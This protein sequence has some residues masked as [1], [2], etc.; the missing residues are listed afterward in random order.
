MAREKARRDRLGS[1]RAKRS[2]DRTPEPFGPIPGAPAAEVGR[3]RLFVVQKHDARRLHYDFRLELGGVLLSW[4]V[5]K[6][7]STDPAEK[8]FAA[9]VE[10]HPVEYADFEGIIPEGNYGAGP[11]IVWD[12]GV[13]IPLEDPQEGLEKGKLL[14]EL[15]GYKMRGVWTLVR[16]KGKGKERSKDWLLIKHAG[17]AWAGPEGMRAL[18]AESIYSGLTLEEMRDGSERA[19]EIRRELVRLG[20]PRHRVDAPKV[21]LMLAET[22]ERPFDRP[23]WIFELKYDGFRVL[24]AREDGEARLLYRRG[25]DS[26]SVFP[27]VAR[28]LR[29]LP[30][31]GI[32]LDGEVVVLDEGARPSF[33][34]LQKRALLQRGSDIARAAVE[35]PATL[36]VF[37]L[38]AFEDFDLRPLPLVGRKEVLRRILPRAGPLRFADHVEEGGEALYAQVERLRLEGIMAK[39]ADAPYRAGRSP[40]WLKL[41]V[42]RTGDF[43]VVGTSPAQGTRTAFGAL[44]VGA[45]EG[46]R[47]VYAGKVGSGF[48]EEDLVRIEALLAS[49]RRKAP[50]C[51][52]P[53]PAGRG[54]VWVEPRHVCEVRYKEWTREGLL[55]QPVFLRLRDD[56]PPEECVREAARPHVAPKALAAPEPDA[57]AERKV[58]FTNLDKVFWPDEGYTKGDLIA[59]YRAIAPWLL[60]YL[61]D[62]PVVLTRYPDGIAGK[63]FFQKDAPGFV[64]GWV[65]TE[66][67]WSEHAQREIDYFVCDDV[68]T[69][70]YL[71]NLGTIPL[72][73]WSSRVQTLGSPD[74]CILDL[75]PKGAPFAHVVELAR[76]VHD[77]CEEMGLPSFPKTSGSTGLHVLVPLG[78]QC[79]YEQSR[80]LGEVMAR[81]LAQRLPEIATTTRAV[82]ARGGRVYV[83]YLQNGHGRLLA[84]P[85]SARPRPGAT[86]STPLTWKEVNGRLDPERFTMKT[87]PA[88]FER[89]KTDP[90]RPVLELKPDLPRALARLAEGLED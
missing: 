46:G 65:R 43:V 85:F 6:G 10:D 15:R 63:N 13:W 68:E 21:G 64:P 4:A 61:E 69:L 49:D 26:T 70:L 17:D 28:A 71:A 1:Y 66:R 72:H 88:R 35:L 9:E 2:A 24:A 22:A 12:R 53:V 34:R 37:D 62:R 3:P 48:G 51:A 7:P 40:H 67:M 18:A 86:V 81:T 55:R 5:P 38:L 80:S 57:A 84:S 30:F 33:E 27:E 54:H 79:T 42:D 25:S 23:G 56:K 60:P 87:V 78:R 16:I 83:D 8:R 52:G 11:V 89:L 39:K 76:A 75:D 47:L 36:Y 74:W 73:I 31:E 14:F 41:R 58:P 50:P 20:A 32:V 19:D 44:H 59:F 29:G 90:L 82:G 77:L 45:Y